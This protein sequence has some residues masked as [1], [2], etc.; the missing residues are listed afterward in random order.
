MGQ[1][2]LV[3]YKVNP[4]FRGNCRNINLWIGQKISGFPAIADAYHKLIGF[5]Y[6]YASRDIQG[7]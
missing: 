7:Q 3:K 1:F 5:I 2:L 6:N 4:E